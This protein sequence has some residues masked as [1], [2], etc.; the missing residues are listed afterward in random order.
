MPTENFF[1]RP[2]KQS[3]VKAAIVSKY[4]DAWARVIVLKVSRQLAYVDLFAGPGRY[5]DGTPST[6]LLVLQKAVS[7][8]E[9]L[10]GIKLVFNEANPKYAERLKYE[11][12]SFP[13]AALLSRAPEVTRDE[14]GERTVSLLNSWADVPTLLFAD[15][16]GYKGLS[17]ELFRAALKRKGCECIFFFNYNRI[18]PA[19]NNRG[20]KELMD[21]LFGKERANRLRATV[22]G[23]SPSRR[24]SR[25][26]AELELALKEF[27]AKFVLSFPFSDERGTRTSHYIVFATKHRRGH[28][29][30]KSIMGRESSEHDQG[31]PSLGFNAAP[32]DQQ[33]L[34]PLRSPLD[35]L[36]ELL[37]NEFSGLSVTMAEVFDRHN[38]GRKYTKGNYK[39]ALANLEAKG[40]IEAD[41]DSNS[42]P[43][44]TFADHVRIKFPKK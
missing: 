39:E 9:L 34:F 8:P 27:G 41:P 11:F 40:E 13:N 23:L 31:V 44:Q 5:D 30:M 28:D 35:D 42:R 18:N 33:S 43:S 19:L 15:P 17:L 3:R 26:L 20:V 1:D 22:A 21:E 32:T 14:V 6:P 37:L 7:N 36:E 4:F 24:E 38:V 29:I 2:S 12:R 16:W 10:P 25:I